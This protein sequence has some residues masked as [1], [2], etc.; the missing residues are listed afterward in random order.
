MDNEKLEVNSSS[1]IPFDHTGLNYAFCFLSFGVATAGVT[2][3]TL[4]GGGG[5]ASSSSSSSSDTTSDDDS[6]SLAESSDDEPDDVAP[7][8]T[9]LVTD[10]TWGLDLSF[11]SFCFYCF[12]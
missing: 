3:L 9:T 4:F 7:A 10:G 11:L 1:S 2:F 12:E 6:L 8:A 5:G